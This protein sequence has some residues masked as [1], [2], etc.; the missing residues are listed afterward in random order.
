MHRL[1]AA[2]GAC[3]IIIAAVAS[4]CADDAPG[5]G[6]PSGEQPTTAPRSVC[7]AGSED[8]F[9]EAQ[10]ELLPDL[11]CPGALPDGMRLESIIVHTPDDDPGARIFEARFEDDAGLRVTLR[12]GALPAASLTLLTPDAGETLRS[13]AMYGS[14]EAVVTTGRLVARTTDGVYH[15]IVAEGL[16]L[17]VLRRIGLEMRP[18]PPPGN[19]EP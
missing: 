3:S 13:P 1:G 19:G 6:A 10:S 7:A 4:A 11:Y 2:I 16:P 5:R 18:L 8:Q 15:E 9:R 14:A 17:E 12:Q